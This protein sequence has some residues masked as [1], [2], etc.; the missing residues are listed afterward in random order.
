L[1]SLLD[2]I[3]LLRSSFIEVLFKN[4]FRLGGTEI[5]SIT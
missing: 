1:E 5:P 4:T 2:F 3:W